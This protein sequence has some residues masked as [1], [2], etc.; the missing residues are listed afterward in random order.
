MKIIKKYYPVFLIALLCAVIISIW[1][2]EGKLLATGE[3][4][5][6]LI[7]PSKSI[8]L[9]KYIWNEIGTG[10]FTPR[11]NAVLPLFYFEFYILKIGMPV[12]LFQA[13]I[14]YTLLIIGSCSMYFLTK[15]L[16]KNTGLAFVAAVFYILNPISLL[17]VW[18]RFLLTFMFFYTLTPLFM[19]LYIVGLKNEKKIFIL[20]TP[21]V[22][23]FFTF[24][25]ENPST[26]LLLWFLPFIYSLSLSFQYSSSKSFSIFPILYFI[27][28]FLFWILINLWWI[29]PYFALSKLSFAANTTIHNIGTLKANSADFTLSNV[30][31]LIHGGFLYRNEDFGS[32]YK[33]PFFL[34]L[35]WLI[36]IITIYGLIRLKSGQIKLFFTVSL[37]LLLFLVKG[38]S[39]PFGEIFLWF[40][41]K[42]T[43]LQVY[44]NPLEKIGMLL[45]IIYA[46]LFSFGLF[47]LLKKIQN[48]K[49]RILFLVL[50]LAGLGVFHWPFFSG[51][52]ASFGGRDIRV[53]VPPSFKSA[54]QVIPSGNHIILSIPIM[55]GAS[56]FYKWQYG[57]KGVES[58]DSLFDYP[59]INIF[60]DAYSFYGQLLI[61]MSDGYLN[62]LVGLAQLFSADLIVYRKDTDVAAFGYN[63]DALERSEK[64]ISQSNL[65]KIFDS[66]EFS[67]WSLS[68]ERIVP[69]IYT[70]QRVRL[71]DSPAELVALLE[72]NKFDPKMETFVCVTEEKCNPYSPSKNLS[73]IQIDAIPEKIEFKKVSPTNYIVKVTNSKG[74]F[75][76]VF[77][78]TF[79]PGWTASVEG[80]PIEGDSHIVA[81]GYA[82]GFII[83]DTGSFNISLK[84]APG[85]E[86]QRF[87]KVSLLAISLGMITL[88]GSIIK[89][90]ITSNRHI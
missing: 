75:L 49:K 9:Y 33:L 51:A 71:G 25:F 82:N 48:Y 56:G 80:K 31:R 28:T 4:G 19:Y 37:I 17:G 8:Q 63:L 77:N 43:F 84:F 45:P 41:S 38:T 90:F 7:N 23:L 70:P 76:L 13:F 62:N 12:W 5:L 21:L 11:A 83:D 1:F 34:I 42:I 74:K 88:S 36:P 22:S 14:F 59:V 66:K 87:Y 53:V 79:H 40:F 32:I 47:I 46:P 27:L 3:E 6:M 68:E 67:L 35:S 50:A 18:Y 29:F 78:N 86:A 73:Q 72:E 39:P 16:F 81:N 85:E 26:V 65:S 10:A 44:R 57:Y 69:L 2:K 60:Y 15:E 54:N 52:L 24:A 58:S 61:A 55:G 89:I 30:V 20:L 64:M